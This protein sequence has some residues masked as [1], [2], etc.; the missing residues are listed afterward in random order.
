V[1]FVQ[2]HTGIV[3]DLIDLH[4]TVPLFKQFD[5][6]VHDSAVVEAGVGE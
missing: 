2:F 1:D 6:A 4:V 5:V 3:Q